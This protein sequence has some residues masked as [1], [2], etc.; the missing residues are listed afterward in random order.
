M[1]LRTE[2][3]KRFL[4][5]SI[6]NRYCPQ[7]KNWWKINTETAKYWLLVCIALFSINFQ[8]LKMRHF[9]RAL[10]L[11]HDP[12]RLGIQKERTYH[13]RSM[14]IKSWSWTDSFPPRRRWGFRSVSR[15]RL[16]PFPGGEAWCA[17]YRDSKRCGSPRRAKKYKV[18]GSRG[19]CVA[20]YPNAIVRLDHRRHTV[21]A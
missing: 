9:L 2:V 7:W 12:N 4:S 6:S 3:L 15:N 8:L 21:P 19:R 13:F 11:F 20:V 17:G 10:F 1:I 14:R 18:C 16:C 5:R